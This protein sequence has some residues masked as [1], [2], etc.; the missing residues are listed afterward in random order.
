MT[1]PIIFFSYLKIH[2]SVYKLMNPGGGGGSMSYPGGGGGYPG[3]SSYG[4]CSQ[5]M[6]GYHHQPTVPQSQASPYGSAQ[7]VQIPTNPSQPSQ[8]GGDQ[9]NCKTPPFQVSN[10]STS[11]AITFTVSCW[12]TNWKLITIK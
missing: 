5:Y 4:Y 10:I 2:H 6:Q 8:Y 12:H 11:F 9:F 3:G 1:N 7:G